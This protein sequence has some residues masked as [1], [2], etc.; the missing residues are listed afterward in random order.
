MVVP[1]GFTAQEILDGVA[2]EAGI[3]LAG[4]FDVFAG[5]LIRIGHMGENANME[6]VKLTLEALLKVLSKSK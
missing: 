5:K 4:S 2:K 1:D 6:D 3:M